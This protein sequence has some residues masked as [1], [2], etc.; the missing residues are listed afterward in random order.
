L[1]ED[2]GRTEEEEEE[3]NWFSKGLMWEYTTSRE[4]QILLGRLARKV[5]MNVEVKAGRR[6][7]Q[8]GMR[9][10]PSLTAC[11]AAVE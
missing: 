4:A 9:G 5:R 8:T 3:D 11:P 7:K 6:R 1:A 2:G 10:R